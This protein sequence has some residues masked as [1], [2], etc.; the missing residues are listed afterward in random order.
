MISIPGYKQLQ[1]IAQG[2][3]CLVY[4][5][6]RDKDGKKVILR[7]LRP[8]IATPQLISRHQREF[9]LL[10]QI[11]SDQ[12]IKPIELINDDNA[13]IL[14]TELAPGKPL[15]SFI[16]QADLTILESAKIACLIAM[17]LDDIHRANIVH[18]DI[19]PANIIYDAE[20]SE[21]KLFDFGIS[22]YAS[23]GQ[24]K[25][26]ANTAIEGTLSYLSPE[27]T[28]RMN[29]SVDFRSDFYSLGVILY[30]LITG[31]LPFNGED[32]LDLIYQH[33]TRTPQPP[34]DIN[35]TVP[36]ALSK[37]TSKLLSKMPEDRYQSAFAIT[38]DLNRFLTLFDNNP[39]TELDFD[40]ALDDISEQLNMSEHLLERDTH[41]AHLLKML[42]RISNGESGSLICIGD[43][44]TGKS[45][46]I[47]EIEK[48]VIK[49]G[50][51]LAKGINHETSKETPYS[52]ISFALSELIKQLLSR[53]D[54]T[55]RK[56]V[57]QE[58]LIGLEAP[59]AN[60]SPDVANLIDYVPSDDTFAT[61]DVKSKLLSGI[62]AL[63]GT[64]SD[65]KTPVVICLDNLQW[66]DSASIELF[67][68]LFTRNQ[69]PFVMF[70]GAYRSPAL[71][72]QEWIDVRIK[73]LRERS[74]SLELIRV[75][76]LSIG[77][78]NR[79]I[80][81]SLFRPEEETIEF[82][83]L[84]LEKTRGNPLSVKQ[85]M[86]RTFDNGFLHFDR[87]HREW[88][89]D[90]SQITSEP[91]AESVSLPLIHQLQ[92]L[93]PTT[94]KLLKIA[95]C[96]GTEFEL[97]L[98]QRVSELSYAETSNKI[99]MAL[100][101]GYILQV[102]SLQLRHQRIIFRFAHE[103]IQQTLYELIGQNEKLQ[104]HAE[105]GEAILVA[106]QGDT[107]E[108]IFD[109]VS[110]LN[111]SLVSLDDS[112]GDQLKLAALNIA[113][114]YKAKSTAAYRHAFK[115]F[116]TAIA[117]LG[118]RPWEQ[119]EQCLEAH[120][121]AASTAYLCGDE[122][123]T[124]L[125]ISTILEYARSPL[126]IASAY[127]IKVRSLIAANRFQEAIES[128]QTALTAIDVEISETAGIRTFLTMAKVLIYSR[129]LFMGTKI[130]LPIMESEKHQAAMKL[131]QIITEATYITGDPR[132]NRY[133]LEMAHLSLKYGLAPESSVSFSA[134][135]SVLIAKLGTINFG[136]SLGQMAL[137][138][139]PN[140]QKKQHSRTINLAYLFNLS[141]RGHLEDTLEPLARS[142][143][144]GL[145]NGD[146]SNAIIAGI[147]AC[148][149]EFLLGRDLQ[150]VEKNLEERIAEAKQHQQTSRYYMGGIYLQMTRNLTRYVNTPW[151]LEG[152]AC[153]EN[154]LI[155][156]LVARAEDT[157]S[158]NFF[159]AKL[160]LAFVFGRIDHALSFADQVARNTHSIRVAPILTFFKAFETLACIN[161]LANAT[162]TQKIA[163]KIRIWRNRR[164]L[165]KWA[166]HSPEN[167]LHRLHLV[168]AELAAHQGK[169]SK[170]I[171][172]FELAIR[173]AQEN[174]YT[175]DLALAN[176]R[177]GEF[178]Q[179][180]G[181]PGIA[182]YFLANAIR[183]YK[184]WGAN[185][186]VRHLQNLYPELYESEFSQP[187]KSE[188]F[189][190]GDDSLID[191]ETV[192]KASQVLAGEVVLEN[193]LR[194]LMQVALT[195][196]GANKASLVINTDNRLNVAITTS[197]HED[198]NDFR[199]ESV[200]V[201]KS[202]DIPVSVI[203]YTSRTKEELTLNDAVNEG[204]F[205]QDKYILRES[206]KSILCVPVVSQSQLTAILYLENSHS[207][208]AFNK[209]RVALLK[210]LASQSGIAIE[211]SKL[212]QQLNDSKNKYLSLYQN[213]VEGIFEVNG[214]GNLTNLNLA[215]AALLGYDLAI[216][217]QSN[218]GPD[219]SSA[220]VNPEDFKAFQ[221][222]LTEQ[223]R[224]SNYET[225]IVTREGLKIW[226]ELS[227]K[228]VVDKTSDE[229]KIEGAIVDISERK[230]RETAEQ[231]RVS[232]ESAT[233]T[234]SQFL[235]NM[236]HEIRTPMNA[237]IGYTDLTLATGLTLEQSEHLNTI[238]SASSHL[239]RIVNDILDLSRLESGKFTLEQ[240]E[241]RL[242]M[243]FRDLSNLMSLAADEKR[244]TLNLP[245]FDD[246]KEPTLLGDPIRLAQV[247][248]NLVGNAIKFTKTGSI[249]VTWSE[250]K[251][252]ESSIRL[253]FRI[254]DS[255]RGIE[256]SNLN[257]IFEPFAQGD[258]A[259]GDAGTGLGL[260]IS[261]QLAQT[262]GG[263]LAA[264]SKLGKG[265]TFY[266]SAI[267]QKLPA[268]HI[269]ATAPTSQVTLTTD[270]EALLVEDN[271]INQKLT[272]LML[273]KRG[274]RVTVTG[275]GKEAL[276]ALA[277]Q[278]YAV[279]LMDIR[280]PVLDGLETIKRIRMNPAIRS[281]L[282]IAISA[283]VL[284]AEENL[285]LDA[286][287]DHFLTKPI[288]FNALQNI[289]FD[290][291]SIQ[292]VTGKEE[293]QTKTETFISSVDFS[294]AI[295]R[296]GG[297]LEFFHTL[298]DDYIDIYENA[299]ETFADFLTIQ[300]LEQAER[301]AH[302]IAGLAGT[303]GAEKLMLIARKVEQE[304]R[305][306]ELS[307]ESITAFTQELGNLI[308]AI[309][310]F[311]K[312]HERSTPAT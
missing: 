169:Q 236:S 284:E 89:W 242:S 275:N 24:F 50:G 37:I 80:S 88:T 298:T 55:E 287:F 193:L 92:N 231:A 61:T 278:S 281:N 251:V 76:N 14:V 178:Y 267:V 219:I 303:F 200:P 280:M 234:K 18:R 218:I 244:I 264:N 277:K 221:K 53:P 265:S 56:S 245:S 152:D 151:L 6:R 172:H 146:V 91:P 121:E 113:A 79:M 300:D 85:F 180:S 232:A 78:V 65:N 161:S 106:V 295:E 253:N 39:G 292:P 170:A 15:T 294:K 153:S 137:R 110:Q 241:F 129:R 57:I 140:A 235:A 25:S 123:R 150:S 160:Y 68:D 2:L 199:F 87:T 225:Q 131:L 142:R 299:D 289:L 288:D 54:F 12:V 159:I 155:Q 33:L 101:H 191:I 95:A 216:V 81:E 205:T 141:W 100:E 22:T 71:E 130:E 188:S 243:V 183:N 8:E 181:K 52:A 11:Q 157:F 184:R 1:P 46:L 247:L 118:Q 102:P 9:E 49:K 283:G 302:N 207:T 307:Q 197:T 64:F 16:Q 48:E 132:A 119:Y 38:A 273:E 229:Y 227:G 285:A 111:S 36:K 305:D 124:E 84:V 263:E 297:D 250:E 223:D 266:F 133:T 176:E 94:L 312:F 270:A 19:N 261:R 201:N 67:E 304:L 209:N 309:K 156:P 217:N 117:L 134:L 291:Q 31:L 260:S 32:D 168:E 190:Y 269:H 28:G 143:R 109:I 211:N 248:I 62:I 246:D 70:L 7:Q 29:R 114:G 311:K 35:P 310:D 233:E 301:L 98:L 105:I 42:D 192:M 162:P 182:R 145:E 90:I 148:K 27:Q 166:H 158:A 136:Y 43:A 175:N 274:F 47:R 116:R 4:S 258:L 286:G 272:C 171:K 41:L 30:Q 107:F 154:E 139:M 66:I 210:L 214:T 149:F 239:L 262:M 96:V 138:N 13:T 75:E 44:G 58:K 198:G 104:T 306:D 256:S 23:Q 21:I 60:I 164:S 203:L 196:T 240:V 204:I 279:V 126:D 103:R 10:A 165:R 249:N 268:S 293:Q 186:K 187:Q 93:D 189:L 237:I 135:G 127:E 238:K 224:V 69:L 163:L 230:L 271:L 206:P 179:S 195:S 255:G 51:F 296:L 174:G 185:N 5:G 215:A 108:S 122:S 77:S 17:A 63:L 3:R 144:I 308:T 147:S 86:N 115:Y 208:N 276:E 99:S 213:A 74:P 212:Y 228:L 252:S 82:A 20:N 226:V 112:Q 120:L 45:V 282:V 202:N 34:E 128:A 125:L 72:T 40:I 167:I 222:K 73:E 173:F 259:P 220:F 26:R 254:K 59:L 290:K 257:T 177:T 194:K 83:K 97:E